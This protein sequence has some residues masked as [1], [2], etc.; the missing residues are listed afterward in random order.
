VARSHEV[1]ELACL[2]G[3]SCATHNAAVVLSRVLPRIAAML[4]IAGVLGLALLPT[5]HMHRVEVQDGHHV[6]IIHRHFESHHPIGSH[7]RIDHDD[8]DHEI[9]WIT[10][11]FF[12]PNYAGQPSPDSEHVDGR[13][14][15]SAVEP[16]FQGTFQQLHVSIHGPPGSTSHGL[17]GPPTLLPL[18]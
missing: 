7:S 5:E 12:H 2:T 18:T 11:S 8:D 4:G 14:Q 1:I 10:T 17:R 6:E 16:S 3:T 13:P 9:Q 15:A